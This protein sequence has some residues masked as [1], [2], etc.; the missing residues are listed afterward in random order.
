MGRLNK[1][2]VIVSAIRYFF[3]INFTGKQGTVGAQN[4]PEVWYIYNDTE[5]VLNAVLTTIIIIT[6][7]NF[8]PVLHENGSASSNSAQNKSYLQLYRES[9]ISRKCLRR[10]CLEFS[11][12]FVSKYQYSKA[13]ANVLT[14]VP[15]LASTVYSQFLSASKY[16]QWRIVHHPLYGN[17][18]AKLQDLL[19]PLQFLV[20]SGT[21]DWTCKIL[22][23]QHLNALMLMFLFSLLE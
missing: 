13:T 7:N 22:L 12:C 16:P 21:Y 10:R 14:A 2:S 8:I 15:C 23:K 1:L 20:L 5:P 19:A 4:W 6:C 9:I 18:K 11:F 17:T 3:N